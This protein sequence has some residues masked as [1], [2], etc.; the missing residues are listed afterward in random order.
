MESHHANRINFIYELQRARKLR[1]TDSRDHVFAWLGHYSLQMTSEEL[2]TMRADYGKTVTEVYVETAKRALRGDIGKTDGSALITLAAVQHINLPLH[3]DTAAQR[4]HGAQ[5]L[6]RETLP[7]WVP[8][9]RTSRSF[10]L[11]EPISPHR[12]HGTSS[13]NLKFVERGLTLRIRG[14]EI[15]SID[16]RSR[17]FSDKEFHP[18]ANSKASDSP[19]IYVWQKICQKDRFHLGDKYFN[20]QESLFACMQTLSNGCVQIAGRERKS[21]HSIPRS[22][23]LEQEAVYLTNMFGRSESVA[24][25]VRQLVEEADQQMPEQWNRCAS[26]ASNNRAFATTSKGFYVLGPS[27][28][29][30]GDIICVLFGGKMPFCLRPWG[31]HH[32]LVGECYV[33][34]LM[35]GEAIEMMEQKKLVESHF[36]LL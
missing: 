14:L 6:G 7:S 19:I 30:A 5:E 25:D 8:D 2:S 10:I 28:M 29:E 13:P 17:S 9:W 31:A 34:G 18:E 22:R 24:S 33:H 12:A 32:L 35:D 16:V 23:W 1:F 15:D 36:D 27:I 26:A 3:C 11:S 20:G 4:S 21:Y